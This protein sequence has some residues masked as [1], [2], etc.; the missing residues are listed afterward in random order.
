MSEFDPDA[1]LA[2]RRSPVASGFG[3]DAFLATR[4]ATAPETPATPSDFDPEAI[5]RGAGQGLTYGFQDEAAAMVPTAMTAGVVLGQRIAQSAPGRAAMRLLP[6]MGDMPDA[7]LDALSKGAAAEATQ[8]VGGAQPA[9]NWRDTL[10]QVYR[11]NREQ[12]RRANEAARER[13]PGQFLG[14]QVAGA[15]LAPGPKV[16]PYKPLNTIGG[17]AL[18]YA[19]TGAA[20]G[21]AAGLGYSTADLTKGDVAGAA[22]DALS[23]AAFG[24]AASGVLGPTAEVGWGRVAKPWLAQKAAERAISAVTPS[25]TLSD[26]MAKRL[27]ITTPEGQQ[28]LGR[29]ILAADVLEPL[30][31]APA[32][33]ERVREGLKETGRGIGQHL[34]TADELAESGVGLPFRTQLARIATRE[35]LREAAD[36][37]VA[38]VEMPPIQERLLARLGEEAPGGDSYATA[39]RNKSELQRALKP[40]ELSKLG[41]DIYRQ[42]VR[43]YTANIY[44]QLGAQIGPEAAADFSNLTKRFGTLA[45]IE[46]PLMTKASRQAQ[47]APVG[48]LDMQA[49]QMMGGGEPTT[50]ATMSL[51]SAFLRG[52]R[53]DATLALGAN[54]LSKM[55]PTTAGRLAATTS[56]ITSSLEPDDESAVRAY[57]DQ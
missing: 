45:K 53:G 18:E 24:G 17:R 12:E 38:Q 52:G 48:L 6:G 32:T 49:G 25:S 35:A 28:R 8:L 2:K 19:A 3:P 55:T 15:V 44:D 30:S 5:A 16:S 36:T 41:D 51:L 39:W 10:T 31:G 14:G 43:G 54:R 47:N 37:P 26:A 57:L 27:G 4:S 56:K 46:Q 23:G 29:E 11:S 34:Q 50:A 7:A 42:G 9:D 40:D 21:G 33:L 13:S 1:F 20:Q 22:G